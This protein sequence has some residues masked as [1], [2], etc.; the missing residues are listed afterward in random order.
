MINRRDKGIVNIFSYIGKHIYD[1]TF[2]FIYYTIKAE[3]QLQ[4]IDVFNRRREAGNHANDK[5]L[6]K[7]QGHYI[8]R[9]VN[10]SNDNISIQH[11]VP[12]IYIIYCSSCNY[13][14]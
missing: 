8:S 4:R 3:K 13:D 10:T 7:R 9:S 6:W 1:I 2:S 11:F 14:T 5:H 12:N